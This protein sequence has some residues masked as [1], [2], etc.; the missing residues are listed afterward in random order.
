MTLLVNL[1]DKDI[2]YQQV[3]VISRE[4]ALKSK[5]E[6]V[7]RFIRAYVEGIRFYKS[8]KDVAVK[9]TM[10]L[11]KTS[12]REIAEYDY[13]QRVRALPDDGRPTVKGL[14]LALDDIAKD[15]PKARNLTVQQLMDLSFVP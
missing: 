4:E 7:K 3:A 10:A 11:L 15:N 6:T 13:G 14:Q 2:E 5:A 9:K 12:D 1:L 8:H